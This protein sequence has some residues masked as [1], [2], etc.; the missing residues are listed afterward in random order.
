MRITRKLLLKHDKDC[1]KKGRWVGWAMAW[2][3]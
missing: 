3:G 1:I 2:Q